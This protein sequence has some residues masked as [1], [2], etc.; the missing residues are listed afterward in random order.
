MRTYSQVGEAPGRSPRGFARM[1]ACSL[2]V[3]LAAHTFAGQTMAGQSSLGAAAQTVTI[4]D[5]YRIAPGDELSITFPY[6]AELNHDGPVGP[7]GRITLPLIGSL[8]LEGDTIN[9]ADAVINAALLNGGIVANAYAS[10]QVRKFGMT[11]YVGGEVKQPGVVP[12]VAGMDALQALLAAGGM[13]DTAKT[14]QVA[15]IHRT[16]DNVAKITY[17]DVH[18]YTRGKPLAKMV[19]LEPRDV[20]FVPKKRIAEVDLWVDDYLNK[21]IP[22]SRSLNY[23]AGNYGSTSVVSP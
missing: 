18:G 21:P 14:G 9:Q 4:P 19:Q 20:V 13:L 1:I 2:T 23:N 7:D 10:V 8:A 16:P 12:L 6:N 22:F 11:V 17:V 5:E 15:I 3:M